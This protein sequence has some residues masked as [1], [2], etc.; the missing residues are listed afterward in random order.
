M[1][2][3]VSP[4][5]L[6]LLIALLVTAL[7]I[8]PSCTS[9]PSTSTTPGLT[10]PTPTTTGPGQTTP[11]ASEPTT[12]T[13]QPAAWTYLGPDDVEGRELAISHVDSQTIYLASYYAGI[14]KSSDGGLTWTPINSGIYNNKIYSIAVDPSNSNIAYAGTAAQPGAL[15]RTTDGGNSWSAIANYPVQKV[16]CDPTNSNIIY[17][18]Y[19]DQGLWKSTD[20]GNS[21]SPTAISMGD[22]NT[23]AVDP[24]HPQ[25][26]YVGGN[27]WGS[28][29]EGGVYK[30]TDG[31]ATFHAMGPDDVQ[32]YCIAVD[33]VDSNVIYAGC[34]GSGDRPSYRGIWKSTNS[35]QSW[36]NIGFDGCHVCSV[37]VN[38]SAHNEV[39]AIPVTATGP[40]GAL[41][42][43]PY[44][45]LDYGETWEKI[46]TG[47]QSTSFICFATDYHY[48]STIYAGAYYGVYKLNPGTATPTPT[49]TITVTSTATPTGGLVITH[50]EMATDASGRIMVYL[51]L[52]NSGSTKISLVKVTVSFLDSQGNLVDTSIDSTGNLMPDQSVDMIIP[53]WGS[54][55]NVTDYELLIE[56]E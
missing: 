1:P 50:E 25:T 11:P 22:V 41:E 4:V 13:P 40:D 33:P 10:T 5:A 42:A 14:S 32:I 28:L 2:K 23:I 48:P 46:A 15:F 24:A 21:W 52:W 55:S 45:S 30:S 53:C 8:L 54:C 17:I 6:V 18:S 31:G 12:T 29:S 9:Q 43:V 56:T 3:P 19:N 38:P 36:Q 7:T 51:T 34:L 47:L 26:V 16:Y 37:L 39:Y 27:N 20:A 49:S 44:R 35:G